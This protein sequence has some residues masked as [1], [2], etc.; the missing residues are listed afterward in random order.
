MNKWKKDRKDTKE[1]GHPQRSAPLSHVKNRLSM[2]LAENLH[3]LPFLC[4]PFMT[5][6]EVNPKVWTD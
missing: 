3:K 5:G 6:G 4:I 2:I 1:V